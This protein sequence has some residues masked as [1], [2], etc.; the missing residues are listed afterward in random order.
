M[1]VRVVASMLRAEQELEQLERA[2]RRRQEWRSARR[3]SD[4]R[5]A[6]TRAL[7]DEQEALDML[8]A[9]YQQTTA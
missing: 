4:V 7:K 1:N 9:R 2:L 3:I 6:L 5:A 8:Y